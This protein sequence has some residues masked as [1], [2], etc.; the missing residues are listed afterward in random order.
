MYYLLCFIG[1]LAIELAYFRIAAQFGITDRPN[2]R[3]SHHKVT[4][5]GG[6]IIFFFGAAAFFLASGG[7]YPW[8]SLI[9]I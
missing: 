8:L 9:H 5:R 4:L 3:S 7:M 6:G 1:L 2:A